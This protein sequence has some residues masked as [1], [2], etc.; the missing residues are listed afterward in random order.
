MLQTIKRVVLRWIRRHPILTGIWVLFFALCIAS[1]FVEQEGKTPNYLWG[2]VILPAIA[3]L[4][5]IY[6]GR[7][8]DRFRMLRD[9]SRN[10]PS[11]AEDGEYN[12]S[13]DA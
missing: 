10:R 6:M 1:L 13:E 12:D 5:F 8:I 4:T 7:T 3:L 11:R 9:Y 2:G